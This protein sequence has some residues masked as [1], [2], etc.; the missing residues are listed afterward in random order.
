MLAGLTKS[1]QFSIIF[2]TIEF[3]RELKI[4]V[5]FFNYSVNYLS[6]VTFF[7]LIAVM[8]KSAQIG[9]HV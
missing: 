8:A 6:V 7:I 5:P 1:V 3:F 2:S 9:L 4:I